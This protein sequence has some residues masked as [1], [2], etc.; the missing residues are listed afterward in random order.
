MSYKHQLFLDIPDTANPKILRVID[1]SIYSDV[2]PYS[3]GV[4]QVVTPGASSAIE[5]SVNQNFS[6]ILKTFDLGLQKPGG[7]AQDLPDGNYRLRYSISPNDKV[8]VEYNYFR[9]T[10]LYEKYAKQLCEFDICASEPNADKKKL[11]SEL[12]SIKQYME[13]AKI[14]AEYC[15]D[16]KAAQEL[17]DYAQKR[18]DKVG[19]NLCC[20]SCK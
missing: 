16:L 5:F 3:C 8:F 19:N 15:N 12:Q 7:D 18:L 6:L 20:T 17:Y 2:V 10:R 4:L 13:A 9:V 11:L 14:K 1:S